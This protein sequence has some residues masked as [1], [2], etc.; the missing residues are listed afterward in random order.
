[1][2]R[3]A[4]AEPSV[5]PR[6][7]ALG[8]AGWLFTGV[9]LASAILLFLLAALRPLVMP[10]LVAAALSVVFVPLVDRLAAWGM[11]R[12][13]GAVLCCLTCV[14]VAVGCVVVLVSGLRTQFDAIGAALESAVVRVKEGAAVLGIGPEQVASA[15]TTITEAMP[16][17]V[18][19]LVSGLAKGVLAVVQ[20]VLGVALGLYLIFFMLKDTTA[21]KSVVVRLLPVPSE[22]GREA[23]DRA[24]VII[25][26]YFLGMTLIAA[27][28]TVLIAV[29]A[30]FLRLP[31]IGVIALAT[32]LGAY[33]PYLGAFVSGAFAVLIALGSGG[34]TTAAWMLLVVVVA[35][36]TLQNIL[37]PFVFGSAVRIH[38]MVVLLVTVLAGLVAGLAGVALAVPLTALA[39]DLM[40][41]LKE[42]RA[43][44][45]AVDGTAAGIPVLVRPSPGTPPGVS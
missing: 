19:V 38:P 44:S 8:T 11:P 1:M 6:I 27:M 45:P 42:T 32:F 40:R 10:L 3:P 33:I 21:T 20:S 34:G 24:A 14:V 28:N 25:R 13:L 17:V 15:R 23:A 16:E 2:R 39:V 5:P 30:F 43:R 4:A 31:A 22:V 18:S 26:R 35:N 9:V 29:G 7:R 41:L 12:A 37:A 36:G